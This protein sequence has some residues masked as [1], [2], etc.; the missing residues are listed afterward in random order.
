MKITLK[1][2]HKTKLRKICGFVSMRIFQLSIENIV[3]FNCKR[4]LSINIHNIFLSKGLHLQE[5]LGFKIEKQL[6]RSAFYLI[7]LSTLYNQSKMISLYLASSI[8]NTK[9][10]FVVVR[11]FINLV[12]FFFFKKIL[13]FLG[14]QIRLTG[15][16]GGKMRRSKFHYKLGKVCL[17]TLSI[18]LNYSIAL[19]YT[20]F[21]II[22]IKV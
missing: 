18:A 21:G 8:R 3:F 11:N 14:L 10:H 7:L 15:K 12:E 20:R 2:N 22:S 9:K 5:K 13:R 1:I 19:S 6:F 16:L 17:Q 4:F